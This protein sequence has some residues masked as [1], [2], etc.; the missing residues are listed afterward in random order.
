MRMGYSHHICIFVLYD[1]Y[2]DY[3]PASIHKT[4]LFRLIFLY[5]WTSVC[6]I[7]IW[8]KETCTVG[9]NSFLAWNSIAYSF[10]YCFGWLTGWLDDWVETLNWVQSIHKFICW[11]NCYCLFSLLHF[12]HQIMNDV[13]V[14]DQNVT[15]FIII[16][17]I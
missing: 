10:Y 5:V 17:C 16:L 9:Y 13:N 11:A 2:Y 6:L 8:R 3:D 14:Y 4:T 1:Y 15:I 12:H 7:L